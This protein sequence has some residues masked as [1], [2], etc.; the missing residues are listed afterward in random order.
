MISEAVIVG[1]LEKSKD[2]IKSKNVSECR[3][4]IENYIDRI[5]IYKDRVEVSFKLNIPDT[6][7]D[8][9]TQLKT[10]ED[11]RTLWNTYNKSS[12]ITCQTGED[13]TTEA[14]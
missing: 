13:N 4:L 10:D 8:S 11:I 12:H 1:L 6:D 7:G 2:F 14:V 9:M 5:D 3:Y